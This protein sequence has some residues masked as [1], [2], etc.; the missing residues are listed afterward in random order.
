VYIA[1]HTLT[2]KKILPE[3]N[4]N[5][6]KEE[7]DPLTQQQMKSSSTTHLAS[8]QEL[9]SSSP[10]RTSSP[11]SAHLPT[12]TTTPTETPN[13]TP[14]L[15]DSDR[16]PRFWTKPFYKGMKSTLLGSTLLHLA[17]YWGHSDIVKFLLKEGFN[18]YSTTTF[19]NYTPLDFALRHPNVLDIIKPYYSRR[20]HQQEQTT[21][22]QDLG[23]VSEEEEE[24]SS[25]TDEKGK[26]SYRNSDNEKGGTKSD[27]NRPTFDKMKKNDA[28]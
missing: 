21:G 7:R 6:N 16:T 24:T 18:V 13:I 9:P 15:P 2:H 25:S 26:K 23:E 27:N 1:H 14:I 19:G 20:I 10:P 12:T 17:C 8:Q 22:G 3:T 4:K 11:S 28:V 5:K